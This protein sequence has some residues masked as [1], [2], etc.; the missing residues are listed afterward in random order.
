[1]KHAINAEKAGVDFVIAQGTE[2][3]GHTGQVAS[4][5]LWPQVVDAVK[6]P[7]VAAGGVADGRSL[8]AALAQGCE[9]VWVGTRFLASVEAHAHPAM[10]ARIIR[11]EAE[12]T[13]VTKAFTGAPL[14][15]ISNSYQ[16]AFE[17]EQAKKAA[18]PTTPPA[19]GGHGGGSQLQMVR[20]MKDGMWTHMKVGHDQPVP[21]EQAYA[22][23]Q[24]VGRIRSIKPAAEIVHEM[25]DEVCDVIFIIFFLGVKDDL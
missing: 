1:V 14:R 24:V 5:I 12:E 18:S 9:G 7:V 19:A 8:A 17:L 2:G 10:K 15:A 6:I 4:M 25:H 13:V 20:A 11:S 21:E 3:G 23:G 22:C 16:R